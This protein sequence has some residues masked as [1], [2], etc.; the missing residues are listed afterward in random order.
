NR[1]ERRRKGKVQLINASGF[2]VP[3]R[4]SLGNKR[5]EMSPEQI[6]QIA[7]LFMAFRE[8]E[9]CKIFDTRDLGYRKITVERPLRL[10]FQA[11]YERIAR[12]KS[13]TAFQNL[14]ASKKK[15]PK[16]RA[17]EEA[18][19]RK[20][21]EAILAMLGTLPGTLFKNRPA[22]ETAL[23]KATKAAELKLA[24]PMRKA[25]L[26]ALSDRDESAEI[27]RDKDGHPEPDPDL[28]D[29]ENVPLKEDIY[30]YFKREVTPHVPDAWIN[31]AI[32]DHKDG[33]VGK[34]GYEINFNRYFYKYQPPRPLEAVEADIK[35][36]ERD[37]LEMLRE[38]AG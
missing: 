33:K 10:N 7:D 31:T 30:A 25:I 20:E 14:A 19:G 29:T 36:I 16:V 38:V 6:K 17:A 1:K 13:E 32:V 3:M 21:Q 27:C 35:A 8:G 28:R 26:S 2:W 15:N 34:V 5:R 12:L 37:V 22:F 18:E 9:Q 4:R 24:A 11:N 23:D